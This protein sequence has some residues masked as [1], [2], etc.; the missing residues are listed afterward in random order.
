MLGAGSFPPNSSGCSDG[1]RFIPTLLS[2]FAERDKPASIQ[3][4]RRRG[5]PGKSKCPVEEVPMIQGFFITA[6][7]NRS[8]ESKDAVT[9][10]A[11]QFRLRHRVDELF[12]LL[13]YLDAQPSSGF[14]YD[15]WCG[16]R[17]SCGTPLR[18]Q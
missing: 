4:V 17:L 18:C 10:A 15:R 16:Y 13:G 1:V 2:R 7:M 3:T 8:K 14:T 12:Y 9:K 11:V 5:G 6:V